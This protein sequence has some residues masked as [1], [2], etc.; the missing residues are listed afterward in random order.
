MNLAQR[1]EGPRFFAER[2]GG[3]EF[4]QKG[5]S[6]TLDCRFGVVFSEAEVERALA[7]SAGES[8]E[9]RGKSV[10]QPGKFV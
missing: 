7:V 8:A 4:V 9:A 1:D 6:I 10:N 3:V 5:S 2:R